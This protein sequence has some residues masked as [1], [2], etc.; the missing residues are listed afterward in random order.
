MFSAYDGQKRLDIGRHS[1]DDT[2][3]SYSSIHTPLK[4]KATS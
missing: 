3:F 4:K 2:L 1:D